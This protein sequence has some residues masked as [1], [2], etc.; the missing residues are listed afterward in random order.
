MKRLLIL[1]LFVLLALP[2]TTTYAHHGMWSGQAECGERVFVADLTKGRTDSM[3]FHARHTA[4]CYTYD[5]TNFA[6]AGKGE[7]QGNAWQLSE[8]AR[9]AAY[10]MAVVYFDQWAHVKVDPADI[11]YTCLPYKGED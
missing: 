3:V 1:A 11:K 9:M 10:D 6:P 4:G 2:A 7:K 8:C 5:Y